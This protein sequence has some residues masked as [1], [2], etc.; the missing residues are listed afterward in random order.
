MKSRDNK[1]VLQKLIDLYPPC[2]FTRLSKQG[3]NCFLG[4]IKFRE[5][6]KKKNHKKALFLFPAI[7]LINT[8]DDDDLIIIIIIIKVVDPI[9]NEK[10]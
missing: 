10:I 7:N 8:F 1:V 4:I 2:I 5:E 3:H 6:S 9:T